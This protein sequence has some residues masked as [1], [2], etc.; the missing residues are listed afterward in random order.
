MK[1]IIKQKF[2]PERR[3]FSSK[4][5]ALDAFASNPFKCELIA[6]M[7]GSDTITAYKQGEFEDLC[8]GPHLSQLSKIKAVKLLKHQHHIG[9]VT[10]I[11]KHSPVSMVF[12]SQTVPNS[13]PTS[14]TLKT[15]KKETINYWVLSWVYF[16]FL[17]PLPVCRFSNQTACFYGIH[18]MGSFVI[19]MRHMIIRKLNHRY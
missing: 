9:V 4:Q 7:N 3:V 6:E 11:V 16:R 12:H 15:S 18:S 8:R 1:A 19:S 10:L 14:N 17:M 2:R 13:M 5:E